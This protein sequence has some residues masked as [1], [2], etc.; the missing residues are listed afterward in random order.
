MFLEFIFAKNSKTV[1]GVTLLKISSKELIQTHKSFPSLKDKT[2]I[3]VAYF[4]T[5]RDI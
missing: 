4:H 2:D 3:H 1:F 5:K